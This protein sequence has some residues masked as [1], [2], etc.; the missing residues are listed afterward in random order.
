[1]RKY[2]IPMIILLTVVALSGYLSV[3]PTLAQSTVKTGNIVVQSIPGPTV[4]QQLITHAQNSW[5]WYIVRG[6]GFV[7]AISLV[8]LILSGIGMVTGYTY[9]FFEPLT[10]WATHRALGILFGVSVLIHMFGLLFDQFVPFD[11]L[12]IFVP[13]LSDYKPV[14]LLGLQLGSLWVALGI[15]AFYGTVLVIATSIIWIEKKPTIWKL[16]HLLSYLVMAFVFVHALY[17][18][19]DLAGGWLRWLWVAT[20]IG[21]LVAI[22][23]RLRRART[24]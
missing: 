3:A 17:L 12:K 10:A 8:I 21:I 22:I 15:L 24:V 11:L 18:G 9:R 20:G 2:L 1:M 13:W 16:T 23:Y 14:T 4:A 5:P 19:T 7:A 6:S